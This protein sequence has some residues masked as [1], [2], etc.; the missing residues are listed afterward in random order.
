[1]KTEMNARNMTPSTLFIASLLFASLFAVSGAQGA[2]TQDVKRQRVIRCD[3]PRSVVIPT[4]PILIV[5][6]QGKYGAVQATEQVVG[7]DGNSVHY[8]WWYQP[9]GSGS[10][11]NEN[12]WTGIG[13]DREHPEGGPDTV[14]QIGPFTLQWSAY[15]DGYGYVYYHHPNHRDIVYD[16]IVT[17]KKDISNVDA[18]KMFSKLDEEYRTGKRRCPGEPVGGD[19]DDPS[20]LE[21]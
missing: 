20:R 17:R 14:L 11:T 6:H 15:K 2:M 21:N 7:Q 12:T 10:F 9:D 16:L 5:R 1:M 4:G 3:P 13:E 8:V 19:D 18:A